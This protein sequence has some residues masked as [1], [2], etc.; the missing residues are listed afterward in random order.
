MNIMDN[1]L[2]YFKWRYYNMYYTFKIEFEGFVK[3][4]N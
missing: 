4:V 3:S 2:S 1:I